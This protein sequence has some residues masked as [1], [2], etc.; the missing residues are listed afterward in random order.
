VSDDVL[1]AIRAFDLDQHHEKIYDDPN[2]LIDA[3]FPADF[4]VPLIRAFR[5]TKGYQYFRR[6]K[7][8]KEMIGIS[9]LSLVYAIAEHLGVPPETGSGFTGRGFAMRA[10]IDAIRVILGRHDMGS[11]GA[12]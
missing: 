5:S 4:L 9:H 8:V 1:K 10:K 7:L 12:E 2:D 6:G 3:G 11:R